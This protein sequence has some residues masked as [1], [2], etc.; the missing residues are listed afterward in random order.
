[1]THKMSNPRQAVFDQRDSKT[2]PLTFGPERNTRPDSGDWQDLVDQITPFKRVRILT[3][4]ERSGDRALNWEAAGLSQ[5]TKIDGSEDQKR[6]LSWL[7]GYFM[8][9]L[10]TDPLPIVN[11][12]GH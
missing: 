4:T 10:T 9:S 5:R 7:Q 12:T 1:M 11:S 2:T 8:N 6:W 3:I